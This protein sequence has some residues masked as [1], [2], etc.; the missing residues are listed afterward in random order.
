IPIRKTFDSFVENPPG[1]DLDL[2][3]S[4]KEEYLDNEEQINNPRNRFIVV[5]DYNIEEGFY[6]R[7]YEDDV[8]FDTGK[9]D[10]EGMFENYFSD[11]EESTGWQQILIVDMKDMKCYLIDKEIKY[12]K[13]EIKIK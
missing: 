10:F 6:C 8:R 9:P 3:E 13:K 2:F 5:E 4:A 1:T 11:T 12:S 7:F